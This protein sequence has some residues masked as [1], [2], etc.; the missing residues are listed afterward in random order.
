MGETMRRRMIAAT[1][2]LFVACGPSKQPG[3]SPAATTQLPTAT[4]DQLLAPIAL[5]PD[6]LLA[7]MLMS[8]QD[9]PKVA[10]LDQWLK[11]N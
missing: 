10:E 2:V 8:A 5:Y 7:Q 4:L 11:A 6:P 9:P 3:V 1:L